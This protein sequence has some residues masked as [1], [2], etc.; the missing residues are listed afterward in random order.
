MENRIA[1]AITDSQ[2]E[3]DEMSLLRDRIYDSLGGLAPD[4]LLCA[5]RTAHPDYPACRCAGASYCR[6]VAEWYL[7]AASE[8]GKG[9]YRWPDLA[10]AREQLERVG[11]RVDAAPCNLA[12]DYRVTHMA[13]AAALTE[14]VAAV[15]A[16]WAV[17]TACYVRYGRLPRGGRSRNYGDGTLEAGVSAYRGQCLTTGEARA[18]PRTNQ[19][20]AGLLS[21]T[22][23]PLYVVSGTAIGVGSDGEPV[24]AHARIVRQAIRD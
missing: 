11:Y 18:L 12:G 2:V 5:R 19:E 14:L 16:K 1:D 17:A 7:A 13:T 15:E 8:L 20:L 3:E 23:R 22:A 21:L 4:A 24:L 10:T 6:Y 9:S